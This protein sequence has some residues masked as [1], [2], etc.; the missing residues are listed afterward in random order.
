MKVLFVCTGNTCR[1]PMA[2]ALWERLGGEAISR[3]LAAVPGAPM[4]EEARRVLAERGVETGP[5]AAARVTARDVLAADHVLVMT[6]RQKTALLDLFPW[7]AGWV[8]T[9]AEAAGTTGDVEDPVGQ[10]E[11]AYRKTAEQLETL[12]AEAHRR[13]QPAAPFAAVIASDHA[14]VGLKAELSGVFAE[15]EESYLDVGTWSED[16]CDYPDFAVVAAHAV[17]VGRARFGVLVCGTGQGMAITA[18]K[19]RGVRAAAVSEPVSARLA[20]QHNDAN[21]LCL[22]ARIVGPEMARACLVAF[23]D[24]AFEGG[25][26]AR[27]VGKIGRVEEGDG[28]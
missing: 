13:L 8:E 20:R 3:G 24:A 15:R 12:L 21:V 17:A 6:D 22:G 23:L 19:V 16:S 7:A 9:V 26:H 10:G 2:A 18:N 14:G 27:R 28:P 25:R 4:A 5:H 1:S 11:A